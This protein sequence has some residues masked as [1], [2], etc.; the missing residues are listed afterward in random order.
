M[1]IHWEALGMGLGPPRR[2]ASCLLAKEGGGSEPVAQDN[3]WR[4]YWTREGWGERTFRLAGWDL[5]V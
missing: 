3:A 1:D 5:D 4:L 2:S